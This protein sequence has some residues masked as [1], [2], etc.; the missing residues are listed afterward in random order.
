MTDDRHHA[1]EHPGSP[2]ESGVPP[3][4]YV[5]LLTE[6]MTNTL[7]E[8]YQT[9]A[10]KRDKPTRDDAARRR[11]KHIGLIAVLAIFGVMIGISALKTNKD[12]PETAAERA[13][14]IAQI[15]KHQDDQATLSRQIN[16]VQDDV[17]S[18]QTS[19]GSETSRS[20]S[21]N[22]RLQLLGIDAGTVAARGPGMEITTD[23][24]QSTRQGSGGTILDTDLQQLVNALW[25]AG[26]E[27]ISIN[28]HR[29]T[30]LTSIRFAGQAITV[31]NVSLSP[32][33][34]VTVIGN[35]DTLP[36]RLLETHGGQAW[37][38]LQS[39]FGIRFDRQTKEGVTVPADPHEH[40]LYATAQGGR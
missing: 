2:R 24:A 12:R 15:H 9:V 23:D 19:V 10:A 39:N 25:S 36:A 21:V 32:P 16:D 11:S 26:A 35:P 31:D 40:L 8:D 27:A 29:L 13:E 20:S 4:Q 17:T 7:D 38:G 33:Y 3:R 1:A 5:G 18:L 22:S 6:V 30:A 34:V 14:L 28:G 37:L